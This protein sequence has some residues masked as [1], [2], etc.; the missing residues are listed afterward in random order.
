MKTYQ[1][2]KPIKD[3]KNRIIRDNQAMHDLV[4]P[5]ADYPN[6]ESLYAFEMATL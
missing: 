2:I 1:Q 3:L 6:Y 4:F 5:V